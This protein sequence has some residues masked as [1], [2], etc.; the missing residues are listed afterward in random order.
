MYLKALQ[1]LGV[2]PS[3]V[4]VI[5]DNMDLDVRL[6]K[7]LGM[8]TIHLT[9]GQTEADANARD[10]GEGAQIIERWLRDGSP[11]EYPG[12]SFKPR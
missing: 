8:R 7:S 10:V 1:T 5:G 11:G 3:E 9:D 4:V 12:G 6:P 2:D